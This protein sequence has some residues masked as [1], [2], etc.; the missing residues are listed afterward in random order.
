MDAVVGSLAS[1]VPMRALFLSQ[2][3]Q[4]MGFLNVAL[5]GALLELM[6]LTIV[7]IEYRRC[8]VMVAAR[9]AEEEV[10][11]EISLVTDC[12]VPHLLQTLGVD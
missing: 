9:A 5:I 6:L 10:A 11:L 12:A 2:V 4:V 8:L 1:I 7:G 3:S